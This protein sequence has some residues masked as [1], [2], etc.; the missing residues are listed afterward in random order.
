MN[1]GLPEYKTGMLTVLQHLVVSYKHR[2]HT[3]SLTRRCCWLIHLLVLMATVQRNS[4]TF[5][6][7][8]WQ[9]LNPT[10]SQS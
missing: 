2:T 5:I 1:L 6:V 8:E 9:A 10:L 3:M 4:L 7:Q